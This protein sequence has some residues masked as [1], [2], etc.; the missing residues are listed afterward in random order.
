MKDVKKVILAP[1]SFKGTL[2][3]QQVCE[4]EE[5]A[6]KKVW[7]E[8]EV[9]KI[10]M[11][12]G[13]EGLVESYLAMLGG[14]R[15]FVKGCGPKPASFAAASS[16]F[17]SAYE[18][19]NAMYGILPDGSVVMEMAQAAGLPQMGENKDPLKA[20]TYGVGEMLLDAAKSG[21]SRVLLGIGGS[22]T[23]DCG[24][25][26]A[27][28]LGYRFYDADGAETAPLAENLINIERIAAPSEELTLP[29]IFVACDVT[30]PLLGPDGATYTFSPQKGAT[31]ETLPLLERGMAHYAK[32]LE[33]FCGKEIANLPGAG[34][35]GGLGA[36]LSGMLNAKLM[37]GAEMLLE[38]AHFTEEIKDADF[39]VT[40]EGRIDWQS[41]FGKVPGTIGAHCKQAGIPCIAICGSKGKDAE[42]LLEK[43]LTQIHVS[44]KEAKPFEEIVKTAAEDFTRCCEEIFTPDFSPEKH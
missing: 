22:A 26:M 6:I 8:A 3:A 33:A 25:G 11:A 4:I 12:D 40:G 10:P 24:V 31:E 14:E 36:M 44:C 37:P 7:P 9:V 30:N 29:E 28:A 27:A 38:S 15:R 17:R 41:A 20:T 42:S 23:D 35:A 39:V 5:K 1:D 34:A 13:G 21:C 2:S 18:E 16:E 32:V 19:V 43:G